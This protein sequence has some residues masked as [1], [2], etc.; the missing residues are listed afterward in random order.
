MS[1]AVAKDGKN[2][3][4][5]SSLAWN[6]VV[7]GVA[8]AATTG[9]IYFLYKIGKL[10]TP[11]MA[12]NE[13]ISKI[14]D[15]LQAKSDDEVIL[16]NNKKKAG[17]KVGNRRRNRGD[18]RKS[19]NA[20]SETPKNIPPSLSQTQ[21]V[22]KRTTI[23]PIK[24]VDEYDP[25]VL[26]TPKHNDFVSDEDVVDVPRETENDNAAF[27]TPYKLPEVDDAELISMLHDMAIELENAKPQEHED[28]ES[29]VFVFY[30]SFM[31]AIMVMQGVYQEFGFA[32]Y[33]DV[34]TVV[35]ERMRENKNVSNA[36]YVFTIYFY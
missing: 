11:T 3:P 30:G 25:S 23:S 14:L 34:L 16:Q 19:Q 32:E 6:I 1:D 18:Q 12:A 28:L 17:L 9:I 21:G 7:G 27:L 36:W 20:G 8:V 29:N 5:G 31:G 26:S 4:A 2:K 15:R 35:K 24:N 33:P 22:T 10:R 13:S